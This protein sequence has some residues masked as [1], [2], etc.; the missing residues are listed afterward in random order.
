MNQEELAEQVRMC[1]ACPK[2]CRHVCPTFLAWRSDVPTPH[3]RALLL[4][5][6]A[7]GDRPL[8]A[9]SIEVLYECL[10]C[11][12]CLTL[13]KTGIDIATIVE[14]TRR[15]IVAEGRAPSEIVRLADLVRTHHNPYGEPHERRT[16]WL[17]V[18]P[19]EGRRVIYFTGCTSAYRHQEIARATVAVLSALGYAV[20]VTPDEWCCGSPL[21]RT[22]QEDTA[23]EQARHN[24]TVLNGMDAEAI[25]V[26]CPGCYRVLKSDYSERGLEL[27]VPVLHISEVLAEHAEHLPQASNLGAV[28]YH[29][30]C[31]LARHMG[32]LDAPRTVIER[33]STESLREMERHGDNAMCCGNGAGLR[34]L[35]P[36]RARTIGEA[37]VQQALDVGAETLVT[38]CPFCKDMLEDASGGR[39]RVIDLPELVADAIGGK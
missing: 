26:S 11:S 28:T 27:K 25:V 22:G 3:G 29:D 23:L 34:T 4:H 38:A 5:Y 9:R 21:F 15:R 2:M 33:V 37:R 8:D 32:V 24:V 7:C 20:V 18:S 12:N 14:V 39:V 31:H 1:A 36:D 13:C 10:E 17:H 19:Q 16:D 30:P 35:R 6:E